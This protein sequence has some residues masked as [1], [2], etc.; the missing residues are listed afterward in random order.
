[1]FGMG[2]VPLT[3]HLLMLAWYLVYCAD[4]TGVALLGPT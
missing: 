1:M 4:H 3:R 2:N